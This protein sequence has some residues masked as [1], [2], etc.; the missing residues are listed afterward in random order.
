MFKQKIIYQL[1]AGAYKPV[2]A[3]E[4]DAGFDLFAREDVAIL[5][6]SACALLCHEPLLVLHH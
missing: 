2:K 4:A 1:D 6:I 3:H 5:P